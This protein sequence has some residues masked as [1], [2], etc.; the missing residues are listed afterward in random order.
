MKL[1]EKMSKKRIKTTRTGSEMKR[2]SCNIKNKR[3][4]SNNNSKNNNKTSNKS[5]NKSKKT[6]K[7]LSQRFMTPGIRIKSL[8]RQVT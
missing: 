1:K 7:I 4:G 8:K 3:L 6:K 5:N 2:M